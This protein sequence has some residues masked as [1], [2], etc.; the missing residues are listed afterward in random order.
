ME[1]SACAYGA[2]TTANANA[3]GKGAALPED[4]G[5]GQMYKPVQKSESIGKKAID[6][7]G[8]LG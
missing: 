1:G 4:R 7:F 6:R 3:T 2:P 5:K 8:A